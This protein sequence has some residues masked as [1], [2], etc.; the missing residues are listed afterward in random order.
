VPASTILDIPQAEQDALLAALR[1]SRY[2]Y[3]LAIHIVLLCARGKTPTQ[4]AEVLLC[5]R[6]SVYRTVEAYRKGKLGLEWDE[7]GSVGPA[8]RTTVLLPWLRRSIVAMLKKPPS[9]YGWCRT[10]WS[11]QALAAQLKASRGIDAS[12]ETVRRWLHELDWAWKRA[13]PIARDD[14]PDRVDRLAKIRVAFERLGTRAVMLFA[15]ELDIHLLSKIG[16]EWMPRGQQRQVWTPGKNEKRYLAGALELR[17]G[18]L[19]HCVWFRKV[20]GLFIELLR[21]LDGTYPA[22]STDRIYVVVDNYAIHKAEA[23]AQWLSEHPRIELLFLPTYC[24]RANPIERC[25]GDVHDKCTRNHRRKR[26]R[27]LVKDVGRHIETNGPWTYKLSEIYYTP[28]VTAA[29]R[30]LKAAELRRAA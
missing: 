30:K 2:G 4:I 26:I 15:D 24:P 13:K 21:L 9:F 18:R 22:T 1:R 28:E 3:L 6:S 14:D 10:R 23:V 17:T 16:Y 5:S 8:V 7:D 27:D 12:A 20:N 11:C 25:F 29:V 19:L